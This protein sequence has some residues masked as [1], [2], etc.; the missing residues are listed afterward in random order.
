MIKLSANLSFLFNELP[1]EKRFNASSALGF[2]AVE[3]LFPYEYKINDI[4]GWLEEAKQKLIL[5]NTYPGLWENGDRGIAS[6][7]GRENEFREKFDLAIEYAL[8][9]NCP[10]IHVMPGINTQDNMVNKARD[11]F[12]ENL[13]YAAN[14]CAENNIIALIEAINDRDI[15][16][17]HLNYVDDALSI[18]KEINH[19]SLKLQLDLYHAQIMSGDL[20]NIINKSIEH[21]KHIQ[22]ASPPNRS[23][24]DNGEIN[25]PF[26]FD[27]IDKLNY[28]GYIGCEYKPSSNTQDSLVWAKKYNIK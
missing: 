5:F 15:P 7:I 26:I 19:P 10:F 21:T 3:F 28:Q 2:K 14:A 27:M 17:Y 24:P 23:E 12:K 1:F 6:I 4:K 18:I 16:N 22:I 13:H 8:Q 25:Y 9:L 20:T 11:V